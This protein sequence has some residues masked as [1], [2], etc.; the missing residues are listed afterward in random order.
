MRKI[1]GAAAMIMA[2]TS[3]QALAQAAPPPP[4]QIAPPVA[5]REALAQ[6]LVLKTTGEDRLTLV[7]WIVGGVASAHAVGAIAK[8]DPNLKDTTD[9]DLAALF[10]RLLTVDCFDAA[11]ALIKSHDSDGLRVAF[12]SL[13]EIAMKEVMNDADTN[14]SLMAFTHYIDNDK[15]KKLGQ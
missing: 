10:T 6:C 11:H 5:N 13:G 15:M 4:I 8:V 12:S 1:L 9:R 3:G 2:G 14:S 7:R